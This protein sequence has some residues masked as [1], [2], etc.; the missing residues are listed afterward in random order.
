MLKKTLIF[1]I[2]LFLLNS[3][4][5]KKL[6]KVD[7]LTQAKVY[8][9]NYINHFDLENFDSDFYYY[10]SP[11]KDQEREQ[12]D[13]FYYINKDSNIV[14]QVKILSTP[15][16]KQF[17]Q[18]LTKDSTQ[19]FSDLAPKIKKEI[20]THT[21]QSCPEINGVI[22]KLSSKIGEENKGKLNLDIDNRYY[23][24]QYKSGRYGSVTTSIKTSDAWLP[25]IR[26]FL[27]LQKV[28]ERCE[29]YQSHK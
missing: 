2:C 16:E 9:K 6:R 28:L 26:S 29:P 23:I 14:H 1:I 19:Y 8:T 4:N 25:V 21:L 24:F 27:D 13:E 5:L 7:L 11:R 3:C 17:Y 18:L 10:V 20:L 12:L 15:L 22:S